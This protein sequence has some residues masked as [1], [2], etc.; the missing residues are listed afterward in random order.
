MKREQLL[1][2]KKDSDQT[3]G[4]GGIEIGRLID[5]S[6]LGVPIVELGGRCLEAEATVPLRASDRERRA[7][8]A[9]GSDR[10][11]VIGVLRDPLREFL[12]DDESGAETREVEIDGQKITLSAEREVVLR[13]GEASITLRR[14]GKILIRGSHLLSR[15]SG[16]NR[17]KGASVQIN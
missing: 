6:P 9:V 17:V 16:P 13:C 3:H 8:V 10:P 12:E 7:V 5:V 4:G 11:I 2:G 15:S 14:D 1:N